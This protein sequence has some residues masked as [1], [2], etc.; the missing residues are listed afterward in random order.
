[1][2]ERFVESCKIHVTSTSDTDRKLLG[3]WD[4]ISLDLAGF[5]SN[6]ISGLDDSS[7]MYKDEAA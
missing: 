4:A 7:T 1:M 6:L 2:E 3:V 5:G